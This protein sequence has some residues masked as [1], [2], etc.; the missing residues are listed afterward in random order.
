MHEMVK[1]WNR[2]SK[3]FKKRKLIPRKC[4]GTVRLIDEQLEIDCLFMKRYKSA[5]LNRTKYEALQVQDGK[6]G[7]L[8]VA[9]IPPSTQT[10]KKNV[11]S[12]ALNSL[13]LM[14]RATTITQILDPQHCLPVVTHLN[15][16]QV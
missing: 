12:R 4:Y 6:F 15:Q 14:L 9:K 11:A 16:I 10:K 8:S 13:C 5:F 2:E 1:V 7:H 3:T